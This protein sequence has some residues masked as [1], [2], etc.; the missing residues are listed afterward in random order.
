MTP[1]KN[2]CWFLCITAMVY[3]TIWKVMQDVSLKYDLG[4]NKIYTNFDVLL[5]KIHL[6]IYSVFSASDLIDKSV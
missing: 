1:N 3:I 5:K 6:I 4:K 2:P